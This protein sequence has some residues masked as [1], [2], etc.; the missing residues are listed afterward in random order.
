MTFK[1]IHTY[2]LPLRLQLLPSDWS[3]NTG[4]SYYAMGIGSS[5][6]DTSADIVAYQNVGTTTLALTGLSLDDYTTHYI[7]LYAVD[8]AGNLSTLVINSFMT[9]NTL[10]GDYDTDWDVD[11]ED[12]NSFV[13]AWPNSGVNTA[14]DLGPATG[15]SPYLTPSLDN[16][17]DINDVSVFTRNWQWTKAQ[18]KT[19]ESQEQQKLNPIDFPAELFGNQIKITLPDN[20]T[21]G[22]FEIINEGNVYQF[23]VAKNNQSMII[24]ENNDSLEEGL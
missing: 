13:N 18:G 1:I 19:S 22:R 10:L 23:S 4:L 21:A 2:A 9:Y 14:V 3:D 20:I 5:G 12:L 15:T 6:D 16:L 7:K 24:L 17:N 8:G 11:V